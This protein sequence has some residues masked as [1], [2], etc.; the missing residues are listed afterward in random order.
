MNTKSRSWFWPIQILAWLFAGMANFVPQRIA[1]HGSSFI[2]YLNLIG[3]SVGGFIVTSLY[4]YHLKRHKFQF[5]MSPA[6]FVMVLSISAIIQTFCWLILILLMTLPFAAKYHIN[7]LQ[8]G[9]NFIP[10]GALTLVWNLVYLTYHLIRRYH[11]T[12]V[13]KWKLEA[14]IQKANLG[15]LK[16]QINPHFMFN[17]LNN[18]RALIL[19]NP[20]KARE[21]I[22][23]FSENF[24]Y[25]L[26]H[27]EMVETTV[28]KEISIVKQYLQ[29]V[30]IQYEEKLKYTITATDEVMDKT[31]PPMILQLLAENA[32]KHGIA[33]CPTGGTISIDISQNGRQLVLTVKNT[34]TLQQKN[35]LEDSTGI[36][37][38][39]IEKRL[40]L[41]Y[42]D[43]AI[44]RM[45]EHPPNVIVTIVID[46]L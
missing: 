36:G 9:F 16:S 33:L 38:K 32:I 2:Q 25:A 15:N 6:R 4:R 5:T 17:S 27:S 23:L 46:Q 22:T 31:I 10:L 39:N 44:L 30:G 26:Q 28:A 29:L 34:G 3:I 8:L 1:G 11:T 43:R 13:E 41:I 12:E 45:E 35:K 14:E 20:T 24:R 18:I 37:L 42:S 21:M 19:E 40:K 7:L